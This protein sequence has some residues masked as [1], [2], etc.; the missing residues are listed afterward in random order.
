MLAPPTHD[1]RTICPSP[2]WYHSTSTQSS[3]TPTVPLMLRQYVLSPALCCATTIR[4]SHGLAS[5]NCLLP[6]ST[7]IV[8]CNGCSRDPHL[9]VHSPASYYQQKNAS[10]FKYIYN[11]PTADLLQLLNY[12]KQYNYIDS[13]HHSVRDILNYS[14]LLFTHI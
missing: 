3:Q 13:H 12:T 5:I 8:A 11:Q 7:A 1:S 9:Y 10:I 14:K 4:H 6:L 2:R